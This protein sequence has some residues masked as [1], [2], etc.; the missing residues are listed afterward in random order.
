VDWWRMSMEAAYRRTHNGLAAMW[1]SVC[2]RRKSDLCLSVVCVSWHCAMYICILVTVLHGWQPAYYHVNVIAFWQWLNKENI[3]IF[4]I[5]INVG[6]C[7]QFAVSDLLSD[8]CWLRQA[9]CCMPWPTFDGTLGLSDQTH[10]TWCSLHTRP[11]VTV[12]TTQS[13]T[14]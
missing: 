2:I 7:W 12:R 4:I 11:L 6:G 5:I 10:W 1:H 9:S 8:K 14:D 13:A 3:I